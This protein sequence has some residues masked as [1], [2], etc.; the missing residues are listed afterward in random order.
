MYVAVI[1]PAAGASARYAAALGSPRSKLDE[2][3]GGR[4]VLHRTVELFANYDHPG[5][6]LNPIIVAG[7][8][9]PDA[10][11]EFKLRHG[12]KLAIL[13]VTLCPGGRTHR[14]ETVHEALAHV[15]D[16][17]THVAIHDA[18]RPCASPELLNRV[19]D[20][21][22]KHPAVVP[23]VPVSSTLKRVAAEPLPDEDE[24]PIAAILGAESKGP[25]QFAVEQTLP[26]D[27]VYEA[28]TPQV[29]EI[30]LLRR[31]YAQPDLRSTDDAE[32]VERLGEAVV[33]ME[34]EPG[35]LKITHP[36][37]LKIARAVLGVRGPA[38]RATHK[39]F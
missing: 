21:A 13:G 27:R 10:F 15:P 35:N 6:T 19:F 28:Q 8:A 3:L 36:T 11:A 25:P 5:L 31:A 39:R 22:L 29:F 37:D 26:R 33:L 16:R 14:F 4:P 1:I 24:D 23:G 34:G 18:A 9:D 20:A 12:D 7:P 30:G 38:E 17:V 2:D 32:L